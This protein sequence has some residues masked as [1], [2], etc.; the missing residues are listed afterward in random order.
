MLK[1]GILFQ[2]GA[3][4]GSKSIPRG[5]YSANQPTPTPS[6]ECFSVVRLVLFWSGYHLI[7]L[8]AWLADINF[9]LTFNPDIWHTR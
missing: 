9:N 7:V 5:A 6:C 2:I 4:N 1:R 8:L 3:L